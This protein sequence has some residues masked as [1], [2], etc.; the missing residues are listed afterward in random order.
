M[1]VSHFRLLLLCLLLP[2]VCGCFRAGPD[3]SPPP[4]LHAT[5]SGHV[6]GKNKKYW[7]V[8]IGPQNV[9]EQLLRAEH[10][11]QITAALEQQG[12]RPAKN[13]REAELA[14]FIDH[15]PYYNL[16]QSVLRDPTSAP[17]KTLSKLLAAPPPVWQP[18]P[19]NA[20]WPD[21]ALL[22]IYS[23]EGGYYVILRCTAIKP[24]SP[25]AAGATLWQAGAVYDIAGH[26]YPRYDFA[27]FLLALMK[28]LE[29]GQGY[30]S[31]TLPAFAE[32]APLWSEAIW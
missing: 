26:I 11:A 1:R 27:R 25:P 13:I 10:M 19:L 18:R 5:L 3:A 17:S 21:P 15:G 32:T 23:F 12:F 31:D 29:N 20:Y 9:N 28:V 2:I 30:T 4:S 6:E 7:P 24:G 8:L 16:P 22:S 14:I